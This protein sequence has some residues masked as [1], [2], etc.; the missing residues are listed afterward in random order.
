M[1]FVDRVTSEEELASEAAK[2]AADLAVKAPPAFASIK[3][4]LRKPVVDAFRPR[5]GQALE[6]F[7]D[8]WYSESTREL[9]KDIL[10]RR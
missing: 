3:M 10:I 7:L 6:E 2:V 8:I 5:E 9:L 1:G 4:L